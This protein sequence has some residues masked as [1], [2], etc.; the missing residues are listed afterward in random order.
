[1]QSR[2]SEPE[3]SFMKL[4]SDLHENMSE[5]DTVKL[6]SLICEIAKYD[7]FDFIARISSLNLLIEN[8]NKSVLFD[9][10]IAGLL[11]NDQ[12]T[13]TSAVKMSSGKFRKII[14][15]LEDLQLK[16]MIDPAENAFIERLMYYGNHWI[17]PGINYFPSYSLQGF[18]DAIYLGNL[19]VDEEFIQKSNQMINLTL[20][21]SDRI[22]KL[23]GY[24]SD[25]INHIEQ[26][27]IKIPDSRFAE[28]MKQ[29]VCFDNSFIEAI[30]P[31]ESLRQSLFVEFETKELAQ[32]VNGQQQE[33]FSHPFLKANNGEIILLNP[34]ILA[35]FTIHHFVLLADSYGI[36]EQLIDAYN[37]E[38]W[39]KCRQDLR[40]LGHI[41]IKESEYG[42]TLLNNR[43]RKEEI[44]TVGSNKLRFNY[45]IL[46]N[47]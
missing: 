39:Q 9:A 34:S 5:G 7:V 38:I 3:M 6:K 36:K 29:C 23:M 44:L 14:G 1:M 10:L 33:F 12:A 13:Y 28:T 26:S 2:Q 37:N 4:I 46:K 16:S 21:I 11:T 45:P 17:F 43:H 24:N 42:I 35:S 18:L 22:V 20:E 40:K 31:D 27:R 41:K 32:V 25:T 30:M 15:R 8:Q 47:H 19:Q